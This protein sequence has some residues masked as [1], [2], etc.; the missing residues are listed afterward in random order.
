MVRQRRNGPT[1]PTS[2]HIPRVLYQQVRV[3]AAENE[4]T[5]QQFIIDAL[6]EK[7]ARD[8]VPELKEPG[9]KHARLTADPGRVRLEPS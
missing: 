4:T 6:R 7:I 3:M 8:G 9:V 2:A 5:I 1:Q